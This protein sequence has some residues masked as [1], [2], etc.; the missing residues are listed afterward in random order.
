MWPNAS[1]FGG[2]SCGRRTSPESKSADPSIWGNDQTHVTDR[3]RQRQRVTWVKVPVMGLELEQKENSSHQTDVFYC[4]SL[5]WLLSSLAVGYDL[6]WYV[7]R[8][9]VQLHEEKS[10]LDG[11][12]TLADISRHRNLSTLESEVWST[13]PLTDE[14]DILLTFAK[15]WFSYYTCTFNIV[16]LINMFWNTHTWISPHL[17]G[18]WTF[19]Y[20][21]D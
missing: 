5:E 17:S 2:V 10:K 1:Q 14:T 20:W 18:I 4:C 13:T 8:I 16:Y 15:T 3:P 19:K 9:L 11:L 21:I 12:L 7:S 6:F